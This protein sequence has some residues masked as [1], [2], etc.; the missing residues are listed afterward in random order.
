MKMPV[1]SGR[2][3]RIVFSVAAAVLVFFTVQTVQPL[4]NSDEAFSSTH[5]TGW[6]GAV[7]VL[8]APADGRAIYTARCVVC[9]QANGNGIALFP[10]LAKSE[11]VTGDEGRLIR[12]ILQGLSGPIQVAGRPFNSAMPPWGAVLKD[13]EVAAVATYIRSSFGNTAGEITAEQ[14]AAVREATKGRTAPWTAKD[15]EDEANLG[16]PE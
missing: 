2:F 11:W 14:V 13:D 15:F 4:L 8:A 10:P 1:V 16:I 9:H 7:P 3:W 6:I 5:E 12:V